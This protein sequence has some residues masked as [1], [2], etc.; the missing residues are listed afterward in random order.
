MNLV[1]IVEK[2]NEILC[3]IAF[4]NLEEKRN[5][6]TTATTTTSTTTTTLL[7]HFEFKKGCFC[8]IGGEGGKLA[9]HV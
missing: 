3:S 6:V 4:Y 5:E 1:K 9:L 7:Q 8:V 2:E